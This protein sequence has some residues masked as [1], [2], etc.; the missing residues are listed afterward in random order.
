MIKLEKYNPWKKK[1]SRATL[2]R[3]EK[4]ILEWQKQITSATA[5]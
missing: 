3:Q 1:N 5:N 4:Q 2:K